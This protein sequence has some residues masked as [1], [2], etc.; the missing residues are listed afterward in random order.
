MRVI[1]HLSRHPLYR[2]FVLLMGDRVRITSQLVKADD[3][4]GILGQ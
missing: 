3:G 2:G 4:V 1:G